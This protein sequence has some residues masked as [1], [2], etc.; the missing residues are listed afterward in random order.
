MPEAKTIFR[1]FMGSEGK[2]FVEGRE[3]DPVTGFPVQEVE[4]D[5]TDEQKDSVLKAQVADERLRREGEMRRR[6]EVAVAGGPFGTYSEEAFAAALDYYAVSRS[7]VMQAVS[8]P[9]RFTLGATALIGMMQAEL[10][11]RET[12]A[13]R[14]HDAEVERAQRDMALA[15]LK[16]QNDLTAEEFIAIKRTED[17]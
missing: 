4:V 3:V 7:C 13:K 9:A 1:S 14:H 2:T 6:L 8:D 12:I 17:N 10:S 16:M 15:W 11:H 5:L